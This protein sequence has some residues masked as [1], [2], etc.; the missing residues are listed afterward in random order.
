[1]REWIFDRESNIEWHHRIQEGRLDD[2]IDAS[3]LALSAKLAKENDYPTIPER[4]SV[5]EPP[6]MVIPIEYSI[7]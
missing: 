1:M 4:A 2:V 7:S 5:D 3:V 6:V